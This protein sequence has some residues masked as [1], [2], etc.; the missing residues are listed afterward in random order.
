MQGVAAPASW[1]CAAVDGSHAWPCYVVT[2][3]VAMLWA[4]IVAVLT[5]RVFTHRRSGVYMLDFACFA[6]P[7]ECAMRSRKTLSK[8]FD[9][10]QG[11]GVVEQS[12]S[13]ACCSLVTCAFCPIRCMM[14]RLPCHCHSQGPPCTA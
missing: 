12:C 1:P 10:M 3:L 7:C 8:R 6:P 9:I 13:M 2:V 4:C 5:W 11:G 14:L